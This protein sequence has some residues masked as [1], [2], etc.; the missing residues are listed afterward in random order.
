MLCNL[1]ACCN[2]VRNNGKQY[3]TQMHR[4]SNAQSSNCTPSTRLK[5]GLRIDP[6]F[7]LHSHPFNKLCQHNFLHT[8][9]PQSSD[10]QT[11][12]EWHPNLPQGKPQSRKNKIESR[13]HHWARWQCRKFPQRKRRLRMLSFA[14][15]SDT[16]SSNT[17]FRRQHN[18]TNSPLMTLPPEIRNKIYG[19]ALGGNTI[20]TYDDKEGSLHSSFCLAK[21]NDEEYCRP[22]RLREQYTSYHSPRCA[23]TLENFLRHS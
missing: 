11:A 1:L 19:Y 3:E 9:D 13:S 14:I 12:P 22:N 5:D 15:L 21:Y 17:R 23:V 16:N 18:A 6:T 2:P 4:K 20:H 8:T 10:F 7:S